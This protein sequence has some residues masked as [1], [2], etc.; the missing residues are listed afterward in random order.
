M[1]SFHKLS[2]EDIIE[3]NRD[4]ALEG[5]INGG[6]TTNQTNSMSHFPLRALPYRSQNFE[7]SNNLD[8]EMQSAAAPVTDSVGITRGAN[9]SNN[10]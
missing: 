7:S 9:L 6:H 10:S 5:S 2:F 3:S 8:Q 4:M 1:P